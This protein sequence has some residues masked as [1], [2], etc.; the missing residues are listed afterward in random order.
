MP[1]E[2]MVQRYLE[3]SGAMLSSVEGWRMAL[4]K[5]ISSRIQMLPLSKSS[6]DQ[7]A[8]AALENMPLAMAR[9]AHPYPPPPPNAW[10]TWDG[11]GLLPSHPTALC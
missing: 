9:F 10:C 11:S 2:D 1:T 8:T 7:Y 3:A 5:K 4:R 6:E